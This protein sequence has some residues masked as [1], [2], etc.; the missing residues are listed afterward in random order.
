VNYLAMFSLIS[1]IICNLYLYPNATHDDTLD[2]SFEKKIAID[3]INVK[4]IKHIKNLPYIGNCDD[5][6]FWGL[7]Q[8]G[9]KNIPDLINKLTDVTI[10][11]EIYV[12]NFGGEYTVADA[13]LVIL[14]EKIKGI[15]IFEL[16]GKKMSKACGHC[17]YWYYVRASQKNRIQLQKKMRLWYKDNENKL[18]WVNTTN[19]L[20]GECITPANGHYEILS[21]K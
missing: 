20:T 9:K 18:I 21:T 12:P 10:L 15:P 8:Q 17:T 2:P 6:I 11:K 19:A 14:N 5:T 16:I 13:A 1:A 7:V 3:S 4:D